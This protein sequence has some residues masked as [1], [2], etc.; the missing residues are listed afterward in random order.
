VGENRI[1]SSFT[2]P[3]FEGNILVAE[4]L[5][6]VRE[7]RVRRGQGVRVRFRLDLPPGPDIQP[8][9][10][11]GAN[12][13]Q[14]LCYARPL[15]ASSFQIGYR[16]PDGAGTDSAI[17]PDKPDTVHDLEIVP[18]YIDGPRLVPAVRMILDGIRVSS[19]RGFVPYSE[20]SAISGLNPWANPG[21][22]QFFNGPELQAR[23]YSCQEAPKAP[24]TSGPL[25]LV[26]RFPD[27]Q[28]GSD[29]LVASGV[30][31]AADFVYVVYR[32][33]NR[34]RFGFDHWGEGGNVGAEV[35]FDPRVLHRLE[36]ETGALE[37]SPLG[38][39]TSGM[40]R[41]RLDGAIAVEGESHFH[42]RNPDQIFIGRNPIG[43]STAGPSFRG[44]ILVL[45][46]PPE[47]GN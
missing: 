13:S 26:V 20:C 28:T 6:V 15:P 40:V 44:E 7:L 21:I 27:D 23:V 36:I 39:G 5:P 34:L 22:G 31:G 43:G 17:F 2:Q 35:Q 25:I 14:G 30:T 16:S 32:G 10:A 46:H 18:G 47:L 4:R 24:T 3:R 42:P 11:L 9:L 1:V 12:G 33:G 37:P 29:P 41:V 38:S 8:L 45:E 19:P